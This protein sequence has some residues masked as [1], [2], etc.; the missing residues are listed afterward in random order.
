M[1]PMAGPGWTLLL[2]LLPLP[3]GSLAGYRLQKKQVILSHKVIGEPCRSHQECQS[4]CCTTNSLDPHTL[5]TPKTIFLQCLPWKKPNGYRCSDNSECQSSC[6]V[7]DSKSPQEFCTSQTVFL[8]CV[9]WRK[10]LRGPAPARFLSFRPGPRAFPQ[11]RARPPRVS[12]ASACPPH[13]PSFA[14]SFS[15]VSSNLGVRDGPGPWD[16]HTGPVALGLAPVEA[17]L[18]VHAAVSGALKVCGK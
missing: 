13:F 3:L 6:C 7:R 2:L 9:P 15:D 12:S 16:V 18:T 17:S 14:F 1:C 8:Q 11:L 4:N 10:R 5:C